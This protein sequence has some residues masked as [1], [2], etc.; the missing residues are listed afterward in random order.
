MM[1]GEPLVICVAVLARG[2][3]VDVPVPDPGH[4]PVPQVGDG[5]GQPDILPTH[6]PYRPVGGAPL[7]CWLLVNQELCGGKDVLIIVSKEPEGGDQL[8]GVLH[9]EQHLGGEGALLHVRDTQ[10]CE[11]Y[12]DS[13]PCFATHFHSPEDSR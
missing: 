13:E 6:R 5:A 8:Q 10:F 12:R 7:D 9:G 1:C 2:E 11:N 3:E 4:R